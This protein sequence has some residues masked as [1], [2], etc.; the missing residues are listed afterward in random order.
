METYRHRGYLVAM[1]AIC[2]SPVG[3]HH[4]P[5][6]FDMTKEL[7]LDGTVSRYDFTNPH[8]Y[9]YLDVRGADGRVL[10]WELEASSTPNLVRR[11]WGP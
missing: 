8:V 2:A 3:A 1:V 6:R 9:I 10:T 4:S 7:Q 5:A 11:G